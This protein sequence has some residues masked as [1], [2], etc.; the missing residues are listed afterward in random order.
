MI[1]TGYVASGGC[2]VQRLAKRFLSSYC[3]KVGERERA[4]KEEWRGR[5]RGKEETLPR[6]PHDAMKR[7]MIFLCLPFSS[8][9]SFTQILVTRSENARYPGNGSPR[10]PLLKFVVETFLFSRP[11]V[12]S[13][14]PIKYLIVTALFAIALAGIRIGRILREKE[15]SHPLLTARKVSP[16]W[17]Q[18]TITCHSFNC[19]IIVWG[20]D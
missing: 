11:R 12:F 7:A 5:W 16:D 1:R 17:S 14:R 20:Q 15:D 10:F 4:K 13:S 3:A 9:L 6:K 2:T 19:F 18:K 8:F